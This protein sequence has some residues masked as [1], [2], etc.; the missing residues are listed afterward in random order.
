MQQKKYWVDTKQK[1]NKWFDNEC[2]GII[3]EKTITRIRYPDLKV[4]IEYIMK[5]GKI[6]QS[7]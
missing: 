3:E 6:V 5:S 1:K 7:L 4:T 2:E